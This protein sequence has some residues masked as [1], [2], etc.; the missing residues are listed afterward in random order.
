MF[1]FL[2][3]LASDDWACDDFLKEGPDEYEPKLKKSFLNSAVGSG[4]TGGRPGVVFVYSPS[5]SPLSLLLT[6]LFLEKH[7]KN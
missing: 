7:L 1:Y 4:N 2:D 5:S 3:V 6:L